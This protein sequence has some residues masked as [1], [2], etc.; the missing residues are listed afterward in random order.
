MPRVK[1]SFKTRQA[2][3]KIL[4]RAKGYYGSRSRLY[5]VATEAVDKSMLYAYR[6][7]RRRKREFRALWAIR[8]NAAVRALGLTY[9]QFIAGLKKANIKLNRKILAD[10]AYS[11]PQGFSQLVKTVKEHLTH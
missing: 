9:S 4:K 7:R 6:D 2:R 8:I 11:D 5:R 10:M 1:S 3:K